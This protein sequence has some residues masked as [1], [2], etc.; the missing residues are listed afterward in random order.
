MSLPR[1]EQDVIALYL[2]ASLAVASFIGFMALCWFLLRFE[3]PRKKAFAKLLT[4]FNLSLVTIAISQIGM[5][6]CLVIITTK[7]KAALNG[8]FVS[9]MYQL[10]ISNV[11]VSYV[12][13]AYQRSHGV[14]KRTMP[15]LHYT[16]R[17]LIPIAPIFFYAQVIP[18]IVLAYKQFDN[19]TVYLLQ[20]VC[21]GIAGIAA[22]M[23]DTMFLWAF[24][25]HLSHA[26]LHE[27]EFI[28]I[29]RYGTATCILLYFSMALFAI[30]VT[31]P[32]LS[33]YQTLLIVI[34]NAY[35][36]AVFI[37]LV[38][39]KVA[40]YSLSEREQALSIEHLKKSI[41]SS[42]KAMSTN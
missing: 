31:V 33:E 12:V 41:A 15:A 22:I 7:E 16:L 13:Y 18:E 27:P 4:P 30:S 35:L 11:E 2:A 38:G 32:A 21:P 25:R 36:F 17:F 20:Y 24:T 19:Y 29:Q 5:Y 37:V 42:G 8:G 39:M 6:I 3:L 34:C 1:R 26:E 9:V 28:V 40:L 14:I 23:F 10:C